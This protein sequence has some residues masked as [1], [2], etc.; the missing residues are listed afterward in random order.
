[1]KSTYSTYS[2]PENQ[3]QKSL[4]EQVCPDLKT[5]TLEAMS[6][7]QRINNLFAPPLQV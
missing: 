2:T 3:K 6:L 4:E 5:K 7:K 1:M